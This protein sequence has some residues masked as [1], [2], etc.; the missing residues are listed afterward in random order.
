[1]TELRFV[2]ANILLRHMLQDIPD[3]ASRSSA[4]L[5]RVA[6]GEILPRTADAVVLETVFTLE[7]SYRVSRPDIRENVLGV[8][9]L[10]GIRLPG[11]RRYWAVFDL[12]VNTTAL[13]FADCFYVVLMRRLRLT[14]IISFDRGT[15]RLPDLRRVEPPN[16]PETPPSTA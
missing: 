1:M 10:D 13:A 5:Q 12:Y 16:L 8:L 9:V 4:Y 6:D 15:D 7:R 2:D 3:Q 14:E 11:K